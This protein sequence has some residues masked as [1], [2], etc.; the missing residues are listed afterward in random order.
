MRGHCPALA[1]AIAD[2]RQAS[3]RI[4]GAS[5]RQLT[6]AAAFAHTGRSHG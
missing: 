3:R 2:D 4:A 6:D 1:E 5:V